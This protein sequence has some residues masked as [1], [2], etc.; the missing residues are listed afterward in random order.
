[1]SRLRLGEAWLCRGHVGE[2]GEG[3]YR[4]FVDGRM[5]VESIYHIVLSCGADE[6][7]RMQVKRK[8]TGRRAVIDTDKHR[9]DRRY[10]CPA[11]RGEESG[12]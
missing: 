2:W 6:V 8:Y 9:W 11:A 10:A 1:M 3:V 7:V 5:K 12:A 4:T